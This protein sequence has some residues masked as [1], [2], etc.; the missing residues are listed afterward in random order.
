M[1]KNGVFPTQGVR[2]LLSTITNILS[3]CLPSIIFKCL[4]NNIDSCE[5]VVN[6]DI[7]SCKIG[8]DTITSVIPT[9]LDNIRSN[10]SVD[11]NHVVAVHELGHALVYSLLYNVAPTQICV[12]T[13]NPDMQGF[14]IPHVMSKHKNSELKHIQILMAGQAAENIVFGVDMTSIGSMHDIQA[15][16]AYTWNILCRS[17]LGKYN[18]SFSREDK[19]GYLTIPNS[20][21]DECSNMINDAKLNAIKLIHAHIDL[22]KEM[23]SMLIKHQKMDV[24]TFVSICNA[25]GVIISVLSPEEPVYIGYDKLTKA[26]I[27]SNSETIDHHIKCVL[28]SN[29]FPKLKI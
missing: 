16:T 3:V 26:F 4:L 6:K 15:A 28:I 7:V 10:V 13:T 20:V 11:T 27:E 8:T 9:V 2:P 23:L 1:Y 29:R 17:G 5:L 14:I 22:Y 24:D 19:D 12:N 21:Y 25:H 18:G